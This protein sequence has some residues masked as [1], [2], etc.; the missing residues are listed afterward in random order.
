[1]TTSEIRNLQED[2][3][4]DDDFEIVGEECKQ[5]IPNPDAFVPDWRY[6]PIGVPFKNEQTCQYCV[7]LTTDANGHFVD[8]Q[9]INARLEEF[10]ISVDESVPLE[11]YERYI[12]AKLG[13]SMAFRE[14][15]L[16]I[17]LAEYGKQDPRGEMLE[18][19]G[20][21][22]ATENGQQ[23]YD[24]LFSSVA[25]EEALLSTQQTISIG[26]PFK[27]LVCTDV[28]SIFWLENKP[29]IEDIQTKKLK[30]L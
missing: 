8:A 29:K 17:F 25:C 1:M 28:E 20:L 10:N 5:C 26:T 23:A 13:N 11:E 12:M 19:A 9:N 30:I 15:A 18:A 3:C 14:E 22:S 21:Y 7:V 6:Q 2:P 24:I 27:F 4:V 16:S